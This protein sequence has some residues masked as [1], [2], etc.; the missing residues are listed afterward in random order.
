M[1]VTF[2]T[3]TLKGAV[4]PDQYRGKST[5][6]DCRTVNAALRAGQIKGYFS[7]AVIAL[8]ALGKEDK[9]DVVGGARI[10]SDSQAT[11]PR[12]VTI[13]IGRRWRRTPTHHRF[14]ERIEM[15]RTLGM[16]AMIGP[17]RMGDSLSIEGF[18]ADLYEPYTD[19]AELVARGDRANEVDQALGC[20]GVG[21]ARAVKL[22]LEYNARCGMVNEYWA[23]GLGR[24][25]SPTERKKVGKAIN[26]WVDGETIAAHIGH[27]NDLFCTE[28]FGRGA[29]H[30]S[31]LHPEQRAWL[32][33][34]YG[35]VFVT[36]SELAA[37]IRP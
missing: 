4:T 13:S 11:G 34:T 10:V 25:C 19:I 35:V 2:D 3:N 14:L 22:G 24:T 17:R 8:D 23:A 30:Q 6:S 21:R 26:E 16:R 18:G 1:K 9:V 15:A 27:G 28:D 36:L 31:V 5:L 7:E 32:M 12:S 20:R 33:A 29:G 37:R